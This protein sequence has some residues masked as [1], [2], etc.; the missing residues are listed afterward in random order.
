MQQSLD[1]FWETMTIICPT[2]GSGFIYG[3]AL[4][5]AAADLDTSREQG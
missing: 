4:W 3:M 1:A 2:V 5:F